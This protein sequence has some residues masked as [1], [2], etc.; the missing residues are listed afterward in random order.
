MRRAFALS[1]FLFAFAG[2]GGGGE[3]ESER[4]GEEAR[5]EAFAPICEMT[6]PIPDTG[7][8]A[9]FPVPADVTFVKSEEA[10][11]SVVTEGWADEDLEKLYE[12][13]RERFDSSNYDVTFDEQEENDAEISFEGGGRSGQIKLAAECGESGK[14]YARVTARPTG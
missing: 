13:W 8:P 2:C 4:E 12:D 9:D 6:S 11:P 14:T 10:G 3:S 7:L 1:L 5:S